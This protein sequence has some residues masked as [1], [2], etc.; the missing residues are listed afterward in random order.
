MPPK[1]T[2]VPIACRGNVS[3]AIVKMF[4]DHPW[5]AAARD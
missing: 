3:D 5:C 1:P 4:A 2:T